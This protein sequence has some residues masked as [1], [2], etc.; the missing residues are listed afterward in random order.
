MQESLRFDFAP[1]TNA[2]YFLRCISV[3]GVLL[4]LGA[5]LLLFFDGGAK[6][7]KTMQPH[8]VLAIGGQPRGENFLPLEFKGK[9]PPGSVAFNEKDEFLGC[10]GADLIT[11][12]E[13]FCER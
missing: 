8:R 5:V 3:G 11:I 7:A 4:S 12:S 6:Q 1:A 13:E 9:V 2:R 10:L